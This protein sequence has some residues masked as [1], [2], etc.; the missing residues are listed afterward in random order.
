MKAYYVYSL[1][2]PRNNQIF[3]IGKGTGQRH[4]SHLK[5]SRNNRTNSAKS[6]KI[7]N[8][9]DAGLN[10]GI[11]IIFDN[12]S[13]THAYHLEKIL[14]LKLGRILDKSGSLT[15]I[16]YGG[17][18]KKEGGIFINN[19]EFDICF[20]FE[21]LNKNIKDKIIE[22]EQQQSSILKDYPATYETKSYNT[23]RE[24]RKKGLTLEELEA[25]KN[26]FLNGET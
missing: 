9:L 17:E 5:E 23:H 24:N 2:D 14:V 3:Y 26:K 16:A 8:I 12:L 19:E 18:W 1:I 25:K 7:R 4:N 6:L 20:E 22:L 11:D 13:E 21:K 15:N 10:V